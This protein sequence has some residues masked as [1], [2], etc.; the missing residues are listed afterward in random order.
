MGAPWLPL[1]TTWSGQ[2][3]EKQGQE[4]RDHHIGPSP[5][6][7]PYSESDLITLKKDTPVSGSM[8]PPALTPMVADKAE[9]K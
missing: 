4:R 5:N 3:I 6:S 7:R 1:S 8:G 9:L 2:E